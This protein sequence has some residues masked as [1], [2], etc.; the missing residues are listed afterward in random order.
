[1]TGQCAEKLEHP[2]YSPDISPFDFDLI[3]KIKEIIR[4]RRS[5]TREDISNAMRQQETGKC[6]DNVRFARIHGLVYYRKNESGKS[7]RTV[8]GTVGVLKTVIEDC[9]ID[10][11]KQGMFDV[12]QGKVI[13][14]K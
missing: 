14:V 5:A 8:P 1:M 3:P 2:P 7:Q 11:K 13:Y 4:G 10:F 12:G 9:R 6:H